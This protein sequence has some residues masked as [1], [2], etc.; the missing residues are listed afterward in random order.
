MHHNIAISDQTTLNDIGSIPDFQLGDTIL[1]H[2]GGLYKLRKIRT[3]E[4]ISYGNRLKIVSFLFSHEDSLSEFRFRQLRVDYLLNN[5]H[6]REVKTD[7]TDEDNVGK[8]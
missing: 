6:L 3:E 7:V 8:F 4:Y 5:G 2:G 1:Y